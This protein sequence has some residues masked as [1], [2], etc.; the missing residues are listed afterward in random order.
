MRFSLSC[1]VALALALAPAAGLAW[2]DNF[3]T[4]P[5]GPLVPQGGWIGWNGN[6]AATAYV[7]NQPFRSAPN[8]AEIRP[9]TDCVQQYTGINSGQWVFTAY[10][11]VPTGQTGEQYFILLNTY[12]ASPSNNWSCQILLNGTTG[13]VSDA[14]NPNGPTIPIVRNQWVLLQVFI[15]F[16]IDQQTIFYNGVLLNQKSWTA[17]TAPGGA[18][19]LAALDL[20]SNNAPAIYWDDLVLREAGATPVESTSWGQIKA[21]FR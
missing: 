2:Q 15:D 9:T 14:D 10:S 12:P 20:F 17:G 13:V 7:V 19:N 16:G 5:V 3:D 6:A 11:Y 4:Y 8:S 1:I 18:L 21:N